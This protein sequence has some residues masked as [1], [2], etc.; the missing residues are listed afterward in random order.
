VPSR[1]ERLRGRLPEA[2]VA[3]FLVSSRANIRYL[4]GFSGSAGA[5]L[6]RQADAVLFTD[7]RYTLQASEEA[8]GAAVETV[9]GP[10]L[11]AALRA[12]PRSSRTGF[13]AEH[14]TAA[15][16][17]AMAR[18]AAGSGLVPTAGLVERLRAVKDEVEIAGIRASVELTSRAFAAGLDA[19]RDGA[20]ETE[21][22]A[23][24][25]HA[26]RRLG[27]SGPAFE[28]IVASGPRGA[29]PHARA[30]GRPLRRG[31]PVVMDI[32]AMLEGY[33]SDMSRTVF[34]GGP[35]GP[36]RRAREAVL[37]ALEAACARVRPGAAAADVDAAGR[38][39]L[40]EAGYG[41]EAYRHGIGHGVGL[42]VHE[43][44]RIA[45]SGDAA[46]EAGMVIT[47]E[48]AVYVP[49]WGGV[50]IEDVLVVREGGCEILTG[51]PRE[52]LAG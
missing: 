50:R 8:A 35:D 7:S 33:A 34:V 31:E 28:S 20:A 9:S 12:A 32:G 42:E 46:L 51:T 24:I 43:A 52:V 14:V 27:A 11:R 23:A 37:A 49:G 45:A 16:H 30:S 3:S 48:P 36:G 41:R 2:G 40:E 47:L 17:A 15:Q 39:A 38:A 10:L 25:E 29:W 22:A 6:V 1:I 26:M 44:P 5:L 21:V 19:V 4:C 13:E 18:E